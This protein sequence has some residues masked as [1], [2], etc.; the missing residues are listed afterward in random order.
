[1]TSTMN[2]MKKNME[3]TENEIRYFCT[4]IV[5][6]KKPIKCLPEESALVMAV[7]SAEIESASSGNMVEVK[8]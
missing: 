6:G 8:I 7:N 5:E 3:K 1:M 2:G 4:C